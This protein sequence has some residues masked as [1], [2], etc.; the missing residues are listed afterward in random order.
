MHAIQKWSTILEFRWKLHIPIDLTALIPNITFL[1]DFDQVLMEKSSKYWA[2]QKHMKFTLSWENLRFHPLSFTEA[3][4]ILH[5]W[6]PH[7]KLSLIMYFWIIKTKMTVFHSFCK[8]R[9]STKWVIP[10]VDLSPPWFWNFSSIII[11]Y[12]NRHLKANK[13]TYRFFS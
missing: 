13:S 9:H 11:H 5:I 10:L 12:S 7:Q 8:N 3:F 4:W 2:L 6:I 1:F